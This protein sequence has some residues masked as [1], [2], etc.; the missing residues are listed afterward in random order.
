MTP[1]II[2]G[3]IAANLPLVLGIILTVLLGAI[4]LLLPGWLAQL[5]LQRRQQLKDAVSGAY[6]VVAAI[7][8][9]TPTKLDDDVAAVLRLVEQELGKSLSPKEAAR[10]KGI[11]AALHADPAKPFLGNGDVGDVVDA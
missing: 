8:K 5:S 2:L 3:A 9:Q 1:A 7:A 4:P 10:A 11:I 6:L